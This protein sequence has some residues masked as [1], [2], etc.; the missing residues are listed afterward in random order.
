MLLSDSPIVSTIIS[1]YNNPQFLELNLLSYRN[2]SYK[3]FEVI[4]ADDGSESATAELVKT[5]QRQSPFPIKYVW[6]ADCGF[7]KA[8][9]LNEALRIA[10]G[11]I[12]LFTDQD[13]IATH[14]LIAKHVSHIKLNAL[15]LGGRR[16]LDREA[17]ASIL[18]SKTVDGRVLLSIS[19][20]RRVEEFYNRFILPHG[21]WNGSNSSVYKEYLYR[22]NG[23]NEEFFGWG[24]ED[25]EIG[26]RLYKIGCR[27]TYL[28]ATALV[29]HLWHPRKGY[30]W[31]NRNH[32]KLMRDRFRNRIPIVA[33]NG[34][35]KGEQVQ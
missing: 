26:Y 11:R 4:I 12:I 9:I 31:A 7:R 15:V 20:P 2:Q 24:A 1:T 18:E 10:E 29:F 34:L 27:V 8:K 25:S 22:V 33:H 28:G 17:T 14:D 23:L 16:F 6:Q 30:M 21:F 19:H 3:N 5:Y 35:A 13:C 32:Y